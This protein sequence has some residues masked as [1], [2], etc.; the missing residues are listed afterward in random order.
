MTAS[1]PALPTLCDTAVVAMTGS[2]G[3]LWAAL[4]VLELRAGG[5]VREVR[6]V[7]SPSA[8]QFVTPVAMRAI[9]GAPVLTALFDADAPFPIGHVQISDGA[10]IMIVMP[11]TANIIGKV[12][13]GLSDE[14][15]SA[16]I[17][18]SA[19]PVVFVPS[20]NERMWQ[21]AAVQRN[22]RALVRD[23]YHVVPPVAGTVVSTGRTAIGGMPDTETL[24]TALRKVVRPPRR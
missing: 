2:I 4:F 22:V 14:A 7:M 8:A 9:S 23:G 18:A 12:A 10:D 15:V 11:A 17:M 6:V 20:M 3:T 16:S 21:R 5:H 13:G 24:I 19:C 1:R